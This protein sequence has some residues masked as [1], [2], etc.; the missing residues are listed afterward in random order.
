MKT[1]NYILSG[2]SWEGKI[3]IKMDKD[4]VIHA[5]IIASE[6]IIWAL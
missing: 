3:F 2:P 1:L 6:G 4:K 5:T